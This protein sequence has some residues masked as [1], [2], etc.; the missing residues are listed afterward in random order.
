MSIPLQ[1]GHARI[2]PAAGGKSHRRVDFQQIDENTHRLT[3][4]GIGE[5]EIQI[6]QDGHFTNAPWSTTNHSGKP[7]LHRISGITERS[8]DRATGSFKI[9]RDGIETAKGYFDVKTL[10]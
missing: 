4:H 2:T 10:S 6:Q 1:K 8:N 5:G 7:E 3:I 9:E